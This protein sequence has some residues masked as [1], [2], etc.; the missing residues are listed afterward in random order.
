[1][2]IYL[3][4]LAQMIK[5]QRVKEGFTQYELAK[6]CEIPRGK[7]SHV[8]RGQAYP[9]ADLIIKIAGPLNL[10]AKHL[11]IYTLCAAL[12]EPEPSDIV[13]I[14]IISALRNLVSDQLQREPNDCQV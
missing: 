4:H 11:L 12:N 9:S 8:E 13:L 2:N 10:S 14:E 1:M 5:N 7:L 6:L 3:D